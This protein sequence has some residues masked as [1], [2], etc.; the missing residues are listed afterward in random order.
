MNL[1]QLCKAANKVVNEYLSNKGTKNFI[2]CLSS[3]MGIS[4]LRLLEV[5]RGGSHT[6]TFA[7][8]QIAM[9]C[10]YWCSPAFAI[11]V[12]EYYFRLKSGD[13]TLI[14]EVIDN[15]DKINQLETTIV[16][17]NKSLLALSDELTNTYHILSNT[18]LKLQD[19]EKDNESLKKRDIEITKLS[20]KIISNPLVNPSAINEANKLAIQ[21]NTN[22]ILGTCTNL[23]PLVQIANEIGYTTNRSTQISLGSTISRCYKKRE[24]NWRCLTYVST[25]MVV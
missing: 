23:K 6:G 5:N 21:S 19:A 1:T 12:N 10:A 3:K 18:M 2:E 22:S 25:N 9:H 14:P 13:L 24:K 15:H 17:N 16:A 4:V 11:D 7:H 20:D 8:I